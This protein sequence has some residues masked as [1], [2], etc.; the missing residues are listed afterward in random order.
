ML[1][2]LQ[3]KTIYISINNLNKITGALGEME[4]SMRMR[5]QMEYNTIIIIYILN[6][7]T[8]SL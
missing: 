1:N 7:V 8:L 3:Y 6:N 4:I 5:I 2:I